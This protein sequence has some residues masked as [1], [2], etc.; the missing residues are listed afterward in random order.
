MKNMAVV[1]WTVG[2]TC[3]SRPSDPISP[4]RDL[5]R[6]KR[7]LALKLSLR[8]RVL[9]WAKYHLAQARDAHLSENA[10]ELEVCRCRA[11]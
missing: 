4:R 9:V 10:W 8:R 11:A 3:Y 5:Q 2:E 7:Q 1:G 6:D